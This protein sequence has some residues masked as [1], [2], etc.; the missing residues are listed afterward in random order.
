MTTPKTT[1]ITACPICGGD[2]QTTRMEYTKHAT[3]DAQ[4]DL[5]DDGVDSGVG[6]DVQVYCENDHTQGQMQAAICGVPDYLNG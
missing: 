3:L 1:N 2:I 4:G 5:I 6:D